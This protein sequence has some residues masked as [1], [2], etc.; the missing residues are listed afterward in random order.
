VRLRQAWADLSPP[1]RVNR[2]LYGLA[3]ASLLGLLLELGVGGRSS[4]EVDLASSPRSTLPLLPSTTTPASPTTVASEPATAGGVSLA[5]IL[6]QVISSSDAGA[7]AAA[8]G[9]SAGTGSPAPTAG[10][11]A[12]GR[13]GGGSSPAGGAS[14]PGPAQTGAQ[15]A[16]QTGPAPQPDPPVSSPTVPSTTTVRRPTT[17]VTFDRSDFTLPDRATTTRRSGR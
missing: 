17:T 10:R 9:R 5:D 7:P 3:L 15:P 8:T 14:S 2:A 11:P 13:A 12:G 4:S 6:A 1:Q 16:G